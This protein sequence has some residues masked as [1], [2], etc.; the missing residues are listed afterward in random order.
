MALI[1]ICIEKRLEFLSQVRAGR[2]VNR[3]IAVSLVRNNDLTRISY[4]Q[5]IKANIPC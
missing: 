1:V 5:G 3:Q 2:R 4:N